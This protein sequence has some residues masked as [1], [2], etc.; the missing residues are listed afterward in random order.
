MGIKEE[1]IAAEKIARL[2]L[3]QKGIINYQQLDW[4]FKSPKNNKYYCIESKSRELF[5]LPPFWRTGLDIKQLELRRH[6]LEDLKIDT[7]LLVFEK[8]TKNI[9]WQ[10]LSYLEKGAYIDTKNKI[11]IYN[12][13]NFIKE[14][15]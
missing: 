15:N 10:F 1:G 5:K 11:R 14:F 13:N 9:F 4:I 2:W 6:L 8:N 3:I 7:I 12:I